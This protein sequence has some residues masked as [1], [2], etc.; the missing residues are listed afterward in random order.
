MNGRLLRHGLR[1]AGWG[2]VTIV[3]IGLM[4]AAA[5][6]AG[7]LSGPFV[8]FL[9]ARTEREIRVDG[10]LR[11]NIFSL[12]PRLIAERVTVGSPPWAP[13]GTAAEI[14]KVTVVLTAPW[15]A[16]ALSLE[17]LEMDVATLHFFFDSTGQSQWHLEDPV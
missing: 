11:L 5:L 6:N 3:G 7:Y 8:K 14:G 9:A 4:L 10:P 16:G 1:W 17:S 13:A 12:H 2:L 15:R